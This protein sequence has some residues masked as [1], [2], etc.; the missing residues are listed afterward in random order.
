M[1]FYH[2]T[3]RSR[4]SSILRHGL[5]PRARRAVSLSG[6][7]IPPKGRIY[8]FKDIGDAENW[9][10]G[11]IFGKVT[12]KDLVLLEVSVPPDRKLFKD[13]SYEGFG[14]DTNYYIKGSIP[15]E[16]VRVVDINEEDS[17]YLSNR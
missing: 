3:R 9:R 6:G 13:K 17:V 8:L 10:E 5:N 15:P 7:R 16:N 11:F 4:L 1:K 14:I 2:V 12:D